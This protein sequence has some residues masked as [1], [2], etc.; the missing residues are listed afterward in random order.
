MTDVSSPFSEKQT[1]T[2]QYALTQLASAKSCKQ[3]TS[4]EDFREAPFGRELQLTNNGV[5]GSAHRSGV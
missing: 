3:I 4:I 1:R 5:V 2:I